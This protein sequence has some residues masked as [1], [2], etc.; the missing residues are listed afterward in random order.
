VPLPAVVV[1]ND[2]VRCLNLRGTVLL[3]VVV[4]SLQVDQL[5]V[6]VLGFV[7]VGQVPEDAN[8][9]K[10]QVV[11]L[12]AVRV[13]GHLVFMHVLSLSPGAGQFHE[14]T[15]VDLLGSGA[16]VTVL[17]RDPST[18]HNNGSTLDVNRVL[19]VKSLL[20]VH[21]TALVTV[22][23]VD[24]VE[25]GLF[26]TV[27]ALLSGDQN[28]LRVVELT[29]QEVGLE[30]VVDGPLLLGHS[31]PGEVELLP[32]SAIVD[33]LLE[34]VRTFTAQEI[35]LH[36]SSVA[37]V[38]DGATDKGCGECTVTDKVSLLCRKAFD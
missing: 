17:S 4:V 10:T 34:A 9:L 15:G 29:E 26:N 11:P 18:V 7:E 23:G 20:E 38:S 25:A 2:I 12:V 5:E 31:P 14:L 3:Q 22:N 28:L 8:V 6:V 1:S 32:G 19:F 30:S 16:L 27:N 37:E 35:L 24:H 21:F 36:P 13:V 33:S